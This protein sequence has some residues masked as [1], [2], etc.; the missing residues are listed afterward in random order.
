MIIRCHGFFW[1]TSFLY[2]NGDFVANFVMKI[3]WE[4]TKSASLICISHLGT[5]HSWRGFCA[6]WQ[7]TLFQIQMNCFPRVNFPNQFGKLTR[8]R[9]RDCSVHLRTE[10][11][12]ACWQGF[13]KLILKSKSKSKSKI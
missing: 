10:R 4:K 5:A 13:G 9:K 2:K 3:K 12:C 1:A 8:I 11:N 7:K 6:H